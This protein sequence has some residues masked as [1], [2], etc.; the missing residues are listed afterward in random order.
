ML[1]SELH[2]WLISYIYV[3]PCSAFFFTP[4]YCILKML[5]LFLFLSFFPIYRIKSQI[6]KR[7]FVTNLSA[8]CFIRL[9]TNYNLAVSPKGI[10][11]ELTCQILDLEEEFLRNW[12]M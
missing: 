5:V 10:T 12:K 4:V 3:L 2:K 11:G 6:S 8:K 9:W 7:T 1:I